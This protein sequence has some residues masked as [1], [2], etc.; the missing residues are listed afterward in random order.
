MALILTPLGTDNFAANSNPLN[1]AKWTECTDSVDFAPL[2]ALG[3]YCVAAGG[4][5][6]DSCEFFTEVVLPNDQYVSVTLSAL[7]TDGLS[8]FTMF[9]HSTLDAAFQYNV[10]V[11]NVGDGLNVDV[12]ISREDNDVETI[13]AQNLSTPYSLG[14]VFTAAIVGTTIYLLQNGN[15]LLH[16]TDTTYPTGNVGIDV[17]PFTNAL[18][19]VK[20][21][22]FV[23]GKVSTSLGP[24][25]TIAAL[26]LKT[27][28]DKDYLHLTD[29]LGNIIG[30]ISSSGTLGGTLGS[31]SLAP[32]SS[33]QLTLASN[34]ASDLVQ[35]WSNGLYVA[36][37]TAAGV[38]STSGAPTP[39]TNRK[40]VINDNGT[41]FLNLQNSIEDT[42]LSIIGWIDSN[43]GLNGTL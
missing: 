35:L 24:S 7:S 32:L 9:L 30:W 31:V 14:D 29:T 42:L 40:I 17:N 4:T 5:N 6:I 26:T 37:I 20:L 34:G 41:N 8:G 19:D 1:P 39:S 23:A 43:G 16:A 25:T 2:Q 10:G 15:I 3:G 38:Y 18:T 13:L 33:A 36:S 28:P 22:N 12:V 27:G 21:S 11:F